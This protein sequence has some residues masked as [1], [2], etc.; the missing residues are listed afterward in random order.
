MKMMIRGNMATAVGAKLCR[1]NVVPA[2]P[3][4]P[5]T[6]FPEKISEYIADGELDAEMVLVESEHS[7]MSAAIGAS[8]AG[9]RVVTATASQGLELMHEM[10]FIASGMRLPI[11]MAIGNRALSAPINI[12]CDHQDTISARDTGWMQ[13]YAEKNQEALDLMIIAFRVAEDRRVLLPAMVGL[14]AFVLTHTVEAVDVPDQELVDKYLPPYKPEHVWLDP[15]KPI[16]VGAFG[17]PEYYTEFRYTQ[18]QA[19]EGSREVIKEA[20]REFEEMFGRKYEMVSG[21]MHEDADILLLTMGSMTGTAREAVRRMRDRGM[22][23]GLIKLTVLRPFPFED[24]KTLTRHAKVLAVVD[25]NISPGFGGAVFSEVAGAYI[26]ETEKPMILDFILGLGGRDVLVEYY[27]EIAEK[28]AKAMEAGRMEKELFAP[29]HRG[30]AGCGQ[31]NA[32]RQVL[33]AAGPNVIVANA[34][35]CLEVATTGYPETAWEVPWIHAAFENAASVASGIDAALKALGKREGK[36]IFAFAGDGGTFD[37]GLQALSGMLERGHKVI[38]VVFDNEAYMNTGIQ[39]CSSTPYGARTTTSPPGK[40][41]IGEKR[42][43][44]PISAIV[45][46]HDIPYVATATIAYHNDLKKKVKKAV[47]IGGPAFLHIFTPCSP[48]WGF[49]SNMTV[50]LSRLAVETGVFILWELENSGDVNNLK[51]TYKPKERKPV[52]E[53]LK[54][55]SRFRHIVNR[56]EEVERIQKEIDEKCAKYGF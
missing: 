12:W 4:T 34:T 32:V 27:E 7:A 50:Q 35:G 17:V 49:P 30:C 20:F 18:V 48:G 40:V 1:P 31:M 10:L 24:L 22:K 47:E 3:I 41:S 14:D 25:R 45:A 37:I 56:P 9:A 11:V 6:L 46:A 33:N 28:C 15:E 19:M 39:R 2:F 44:K 8:A 5:S 55:Q 38:Y 53:Y 36:T 52:I 43:K 26:N 29:G 23:V 16:T 21:Y 51:V 13:F 42:P 54:L